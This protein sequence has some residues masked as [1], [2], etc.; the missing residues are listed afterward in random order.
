MLRTPPCPQALCY[1]L[2]SLL[3]CFIK[4]SFSKGTSCTSQVLAA[5]TLVYYVIGRFG[6]LGI[7]I[8][9]VLRFSLLR[10]VFDSC[11]PVPRGQEDVRM[12]G[13]C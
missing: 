7:L 12:C 13:G 10:C 2:I 4:L 11:V 3:Y 9:R 8:T 5:G 1:V 6:V